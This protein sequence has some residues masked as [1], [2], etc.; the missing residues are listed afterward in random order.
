MKDGTHDGFR[1][2]PPVLVDP[3]AFCVWRAGL[4]TGPIIDREGPGLA[5]VVRVA[6]LVRLGV[7][8]EGGSG[9]GGVPGSDTM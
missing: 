4:M 5:C 1:G 3:E 6:L 9:F 7:A 2:L 8:T